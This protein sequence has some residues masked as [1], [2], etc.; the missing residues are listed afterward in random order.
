MPHS[1][2]RE[3]HLSKTLRKLQPGRTLD[4]KKAIKN[5]LFYHFNNKLKIIISLSF[6]NC[7]FK[8]TMFIFL[9]PR[10]NTKQTI[11]DTVSNT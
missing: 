8:K 2:S 4:I 7:T 9:F 3:P 11:A 5:V 10:L 1:F 6:L